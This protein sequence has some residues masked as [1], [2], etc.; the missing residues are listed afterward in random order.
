[1]GLP[2]HYSLQVVHTHMLK[3]ANGPTTH[4]TASRQEAGMECGTIDAT[5]YSERCGMWGE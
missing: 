5:A 4:A 1:M 2:K 3:P